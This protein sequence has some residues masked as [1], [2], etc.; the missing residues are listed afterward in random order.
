M[1]Y[2]YGETRS[3]KGGIPTGGADQNQAYGV[4]TA[5]EHPV[6]IISG[7]VRSGDAG[8][9]YCLA[10]VPPSFPSLDGNVTITGGNQGVIVL[11]SA[12]LGGVFT[13]EAPGSVYATWTDES[14]PIKTYYPN[15][16]IIPPYHHVVVWP[17]SAN[18][19]SDFVVYLLGMDLVKPG[20]R[21]Y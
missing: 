16:W 10:I 4:F 15:N 20:Q 5:G 1:Y 8:E 12:I 13:A 6:E 14:V 11:N 7:T 2:C 3:Q 19:A 17:T 21:N 9:F 18:S